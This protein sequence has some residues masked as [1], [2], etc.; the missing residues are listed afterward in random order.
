VSGQVELARLKRQALSSDLPSDPTTA[1]QPQNNHDHGNDQQD[2]NESTQ[3]KGAHQPKQPQNKQQNC[4]CFQQDV[5][6][7]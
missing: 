4:D 3:R 6:S 7:T 1:H 2:V 5:C